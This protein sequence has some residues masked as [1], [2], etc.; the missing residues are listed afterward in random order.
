MNNARLLVWSFILV[1]ILA[2]GVLGWWHWTAM[3][4]ARTS[5]AV[6][7]R[8]SVS[9]A[10][11]KMVQSKPETVPCKPETIVKMPAPV[12]NTSVAVTSTAPLPAGGETVS[13]TLDAA[14]LLRELRE[15]AAKDPEKVLAEVLQ[16][17]PGAERDRAL[18]SVCY[19]VAEDDPAAA[20][21]LAQRL[22]LDQSGLQENIVQQWV[23]TDPSSALVWVDKQPAGQAREALM[24]RVAFVLSKNDPTDAATL[25]LDQIPPGPEQNEA[26]MAVLHQWALRNMVG[27]AHW[28]Q[29]F[30]PGP[31]RERALNELEGVEKYQEA[32]ASQ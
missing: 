19:G 3:S 11:A 26:V 22:H 12:K 27:A 16:W 31:L 2:T 5:S 32:L 24:M 13:N 7:H 14:A 25:V 21:S 23:T 20:L 9:A 17:P 8:P 15:T 28:V 18:Q 6:V 4:V 10:D 1:V 30:Q 29:S